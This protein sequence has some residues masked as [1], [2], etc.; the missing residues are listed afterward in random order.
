MT[1]ED[2]IQKLEEVSANIENVPLSEVA[3]LLR[4]AAIRLRNL[5][6][7]EVIDDEVE[8]EFQ[9]LMRDMNAPD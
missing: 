9:Q 7:P 1:R 6:P 8:R 5:P 3:S 2:F 4:R